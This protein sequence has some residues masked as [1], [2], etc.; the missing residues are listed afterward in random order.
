MLCTPAAV[1]PAFVSRLPRQ[2]TSSVCMY[3]LFNSA[4]ER[5]MNRL[6][7]RTFKHIVTQEMAFFDKVRVGEL[8][9]RLSE[10]S[11]QSCPA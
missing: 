6:R 9:N 5:V 4:A 1:L 2:L 8:V 10:V 11:P 3:R 7:C